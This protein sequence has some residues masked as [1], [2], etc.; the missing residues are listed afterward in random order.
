MGMNHTAFLQRVYFFSDLG[1]DVL[2]RINSLCHEEQKKAGDVL[3]EEGDPADKF[4][5]IQEGSVEVWK[6][7]AHGTKDLLAVHGPGHLFGEMALIDDLPRSATV[8]V[9]EPVYMITIYRE[10][11]RDIIRENSEVALSIMRS[12]SAMVRKS[13]DTYVNQLQRR[14]IELERANKELRQA[15][16]DLLRAERLSTLGKFSSMILH[17]IRNPIS[18]LKGY[19]QMITMGPGEEKSAEYGGRIVSEAERLNR[20][21]GELL[22]YSRGEIRLNLS[23]VAV[24]HLLNQ[25][26]DLMA[27]S[28]R[29]R[30]IR[31]ETDYGSR[32]SV[33][34][35][36]DRMMR[37]VTNVA[38][39]SRKAMPR[40]GVLTLASRREEKNLILEVS[41]TGVGMSDEVRDQIFE[42]FFSSSES[43]GTGLGML[44]VKNVV[45]AH[46]GHL[47]IDSQPGKGTLVRMVLPFRG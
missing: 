8:V 6:E 21:A 47:E 17:D 18:V 41:D 15:Q 9:K 37:C 28:C 42:P 23:V 4:Y 35:D 45:E 22:D 24:D 26:K 2:D 1:Q 30:G 34:L 46:E 32:D 25:V 13:N 5:M 33:L 27:D 10:D 31:L 38:D 39:N 11:F 20:L 19:A 16:R 3:F 36:M 14:N 44:I 12:V 40:G 7:S 29:M 43:G